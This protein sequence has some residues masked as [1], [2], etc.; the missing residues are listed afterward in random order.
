MRLSRW[1]V[2]TRSIGLSFLRPVLHA[3][4]KNA[5]HALTS[6]R[7]ELAP[8]PRF[9]QSMMSLPVMSSG[10]FRVLSARCPTTYYQFSMVLGELPCAR[11]APTHSSSQGVHSRGGCL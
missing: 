3:Q 5:V 7:L 1:T 2:G 10:L 9:S 4:P 6:E 11:I 8:T